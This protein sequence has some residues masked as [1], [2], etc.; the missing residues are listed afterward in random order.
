MK[1]E[2]HDSGLSGT[3]GRELTEEGVCVWGREGFTRRGHSNWVLED[4][5]GEGLL[6]GD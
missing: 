4:E 6:R 5:W 2:N 1:D 3:A